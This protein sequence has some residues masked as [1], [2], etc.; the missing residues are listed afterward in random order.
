MRLIS[1]VLNGYTSVFRDTCSAMESLIVQM[2]PM[3]SRAMAAQ[4]DIRGV[5]KVK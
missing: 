3:S 2:A 1:N 5:L 4:L